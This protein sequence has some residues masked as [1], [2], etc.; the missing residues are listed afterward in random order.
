[1][2]LSYGFDGVN[3][4]LYVSEAVGTFLTPTKVGVFIQNFGGAFT[5]SGAVRSWSV[6]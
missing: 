2:S 4:N 5:M 6:T 3:F 1:M